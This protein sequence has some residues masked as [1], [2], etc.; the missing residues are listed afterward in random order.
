MAAVETGGALY[1][2]VITE[3]CFT[4][5]CEPEIVKIVD[6]KVAET[7]GLPGADTIPAQSDYPFLV[8]WMIAQ[9]VDGDGADELWLSYNIVGEPEPAIGSTTRSHVAVLAPGD[10]AIRFHLVHGEY[11]ETGS[12]ETCVSTL[13]AVDADCDG[14]VDLVE[15]QTCE[16]GECSSDDEYADKPEWCDEAGPTPAYTVHDGGAGGVYLT[17]D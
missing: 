7:T 8:E 3:D 9:D 2:V 15:A 10:L 11:P 5:A 4:G 1:A 13:T 17:R 14:D 6:G 16:N 12:L